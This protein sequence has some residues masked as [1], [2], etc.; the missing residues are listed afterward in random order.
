MKTPDQSGMAG[1]FG[2]YCTISEAVQHIGSVLP[3][4]YINEFVLCLSG[5]CWV[6][7]V[8]TIE[9]FPSVGS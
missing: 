4:S 8:T 2:L 5:S 9:T 6:G 7:G 3:F 1:A